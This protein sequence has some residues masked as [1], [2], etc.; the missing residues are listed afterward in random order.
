MTKSHY[1][2][3][4]VGTALRD[5]MF[6]TT[7]AETFLNPKHDPTK[8]KLIGFEYGAK[9]HSA[10]VWQFHGG[11]ASNTAV[12]IARLGLRNAA[13]VR[14]GN[15][16]A[17]QEIRQ[18]LKRER[19]ATKLIQRDSKHPTGF[20]FLVVEKRTNEHVVFAHYGANE[21]LHISSALLRSFSTDWFYVSSLS[22][23]HWPAMMRQLCATTAQVAWNPGAIQLAA[24]AAMKK[25]L[26]HITAL[27]VNQD[28]A[29]E[30]ALQTGVKKTGQTLSL[31]QL[32]HHLHH[33]GPQLV[34]ITAGHQG[35]WVYN[36][37][38]IFS[39]RPKPDHPKDTTG[40]GDCFGSSF[41]TGLVRFEGDIQPALRLALLNATALVQQIGAQ[42]GL[43]TW[44]KLQKKLRQ[45]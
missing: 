18:H 2:I 22:G 21:Q 12:G 5:T 9:I 44:T 20:S 23:R 3:V 42:N 19:V 1:Q 6:Y 32:L 39:I 25:I 33:L 4:S 10:E 11:G 26:P 17:G 40:A 13:L 45:K 43:L 38:Q 14:L 34:L 16:A 31:K 36:G 27:I 37:E 35:A 7:A 41:I 29:T 15:D 28:E 24:V 8:L 30:L